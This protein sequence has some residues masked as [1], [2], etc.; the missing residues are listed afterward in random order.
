[1]GIIR[2]IN[3]LLLHDV[4]NAVRTMP[5]REWVFPHPVGVGMLTFLK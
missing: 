2:H 3:M 1:M 4:T 5:D